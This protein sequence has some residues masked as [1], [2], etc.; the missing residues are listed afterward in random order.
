MVAVAGNTAI[1]VVEDDPDVRE[2]VRSTLAESYAVDCAEDVPSAL[3]YFDAHRP[4]VVL[5]DCILPG[6]GMTEILARAD[7]MHLEVVLMSGDTE[8]LMHL[9][10]LGYPCLR[11]PFRLADLLAAV[12]G[13]LSVGLART[14]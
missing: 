4:G 12:D 8:M 14:Q 3:S 1:L 10:A 11:K 6:G 2:A 5:L 9:A 13:G 7:A